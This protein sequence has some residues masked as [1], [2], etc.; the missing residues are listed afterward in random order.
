V[1]EA[2][3]MAAAEVAEDNDNKQKSDVAT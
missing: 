3:T 1:E 2:A